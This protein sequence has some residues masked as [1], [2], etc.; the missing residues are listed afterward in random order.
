MEVLYKGISIEVTQE[1]KGPA[2][3]LLHGFLE[4]SSMWDDMIPQLS[5]RNRIIRF[6]LLGHG[7]T[8]CLG[9]VHSMEE[10]AEQVHA[11]ITELG[12]R[13]VAIIGHSMGG[14]VALAYAE[15]YP[16]NLK[17]LGL[18]YSTARADSDLKKRDRDRA[19]ATVKKDAKSFVRI[20]IPNLFRP[21]S[22][23]LFRPAIKDIKKKALATPVRG[24]VAAL[25]GMKNR[26][27]REVILHFAPYPILF[28][29][30]KKDPVLALEASEEQMQA[31]SV[32]HKLLTPDG[33]MGHIENAEETTRAIYR[34]IT[35][36]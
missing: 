9:Y 12:L 23:E 34:F 20:A 33:H 11:V 21:K 1:G 17:G 7:K 8:D 4:D 29:A 30:G 28:V 36:L 31:P 22:R 16:D 32:S 2:V 24:I 27:D 18:F 19:I 35:S 3:I 6:D 13:K 25:E 10:M 5:K 15:L 14:Y 26:P